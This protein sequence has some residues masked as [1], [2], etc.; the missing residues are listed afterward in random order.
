MVVCTNEQGLFFMA[1]VS[2]KGWYTARKL[3]HFDVP[4]TL[5][6]ITFR[7]G[8]ALPQSVLREL[9]KKTCR[10]PADQR[11]RSQRENIEYWLDQGLGCCVLRCSEMA[12]VLRESLVF[13]HGRRY[14]LVAWCIMPNHVHVVI[15]PTYSLPRIVQGW[16]SYSARWALMHG[17]KSGLTLPYGQFWMRGYWDRYIRDVRHYQ[18]AVLYVHQNPVKAGLCKRAEDWRWSSAYKGA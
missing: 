7:L 9:R 15:E 14:E 18:A 5:Q 13:H 12:E 2:H 3:P 6:F 8:D 1:I 4:H 10:L 16:K 11:A 17:S